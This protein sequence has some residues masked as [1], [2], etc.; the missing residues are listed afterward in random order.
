MRPLIPALAAVLMAPPLAAQPVEPAPA[1]TPAPAAESNDQGLEPQITI[2][3]RGPEIVEEYRLNG[4]LYM[5]KI[6]P[7]KGLPYYL[8]DT[9]GDG[10]FDV[11]RHD[12]DPKVS[13][14]QWVLFHW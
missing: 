7:S 13:I 10:S 14:P 5:L 2:I 12:L 1:V 11:R 8:I 9:K 4:R 6:T 3:H